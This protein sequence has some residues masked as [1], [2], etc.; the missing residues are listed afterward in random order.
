MR[1]LNLAALDRTPGLAA[2][3][4]AALAQLTN[5]TALSFDAGDELEGRLQDTCPHL[6]SLP[7]LAALRLHQSSLQGCA[8][9][10]AMTEIQLFNLF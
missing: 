5:L 10:A 2:A 4:D 9:L 6:L 7:R 3:L 8:A 1:R